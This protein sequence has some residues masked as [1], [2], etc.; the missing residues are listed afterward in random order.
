[1]DI[2]M[3][4]YQS[5]LFQLAF[6]GFIITSIMTL[7]FSAYARRGYSADIDSLKYTDEV[8]DRVLRASIIWIRQDASQSFTAL[9]I[10][11]GLLGAILLVLIFKL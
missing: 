6:L 1:M 3:T 4:I 8:D 2:I 10:I 5:E 11:S 7:L 9:T